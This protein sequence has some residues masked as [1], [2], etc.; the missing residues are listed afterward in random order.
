MFN[1]LSTVTPWSLVA[2]GYRKSTQ[3]FLEQYSLKAIELIQPTKHDTALDVATGPGTLAIPLSKLV[4]EVTG[5]DFSP[6]M[7]EE[8]KKNLI[9]GGVQNVIPLEMD[10]QDLRFADHTFDIA[11]S[12]FGLI[13][14]PDKLKGMKELYRVLRPGGRVS[15]SSWGPIS[16]SNMMQLLFGA[17]RKASPE[18]PEPQTNIA[19]L[20]NPE[21]FKEQLG[22]A[23]FKNIE[24][25]AYAPPMEITN[26]D[27]F[28]D[29]ML[30][31]NA[32][33]QLMKSKMTEPQWKEKN[34]IMKSYVRETLDKL[35]TT[36]SSQAYI[37]IA[38]K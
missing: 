29:M 3:P 28:Y 19:S 33:L 27:D 37:G 30:E 20:E 5:I 1:P 32:P 35:P 4:S 6:L 17:I 13:F 21:Y 14:F 8:L 11:F 15:I 31:G 26:A 12:M 9:L 18:M 7:I 36:L 2:E 25:H 10:G 24:I 38:S 34:Q 23:G 22:I 16:N